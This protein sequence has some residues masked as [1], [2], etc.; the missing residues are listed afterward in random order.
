MAAGGAIP[1]IT[2]TELWNGITW[3]EVNDM[4]D[5]NASYG[6]AGNACAAIYQQTYPFGTTKNQCWNGTNWSEVA[7][8]GYAAS[9]K[10]GDGTA[11]AA[12]FSGGHT[13]SNTAAVSEWNGSVFYDGPNMPTAKTDHA[14][15]GFQ[16]AAYVFGGNA[17]ASPSTETVKYDGTSW[18]TDVNLPQGIRAHTGSGTSNAAL[19]AA[20]SEP[21]TTANTNEYNGVA[22]HA[23]GALS[24]ARKYTNMDGTQAGTIIAGG[25]PSGALTEIYTT[26]GIGCACIGGV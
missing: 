21:A 24:S 12:I 19:S 6:I 5:A 1:A 18:A 3:T 17:P 10:Q 9:N 11:N 7:D 26:T 15:A 13:P 16:N 14:Q 22:W 23:G 8:G 2:C 4:V 20:G 25:S